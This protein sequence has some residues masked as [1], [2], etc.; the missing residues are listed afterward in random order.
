[1]HRVED[2]A[3]IV[4]E[5]PEHGPGARRGRG[6]RDVP[7][8]EADDR[9]HLA[10]GWDGRWMSASARQPECAEQRRRERER[11]AG[12]ERLAEP[13]DDVR[14]CRVRVWSIV[15]WMGRRDDRRRTVRRSVRIGRRFAANHEVIPRYQQGEGPGWSFDGPNLLRTERTARSL[16]RDCCARHDGIADDPDERHLCVVGHAF[17]ASRGERDPIRS[18][19]AP[20]VAAPRR[21]RPGGRGSPVR[22]QPLRGHDGQAGARPAPASAAA[23]RL[24]GRFAPGDRVGRP[25]HS[26]AGRDSSAGAGTRVRRRSGSRHRGRRLPRLVRRA[27]GRHAGAAGLWNPGVPLRRRC[28]GTPSGPSRR[29]CS[30]T[31]RWSPGRWRGTTG[32]W[33]SVGSEPRHTSRRS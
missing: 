27:P 13:F 19:H 21:S 10:G 17:H 15:G 31:P 14:S 2:S 1:V 25:E 22:G 29:I 4:D 26:R 33:P 18:I 9:E 24:L 32:G 7:P 3:A 6:R 8:T 28:S 5:R 12:A 11:C 23:P 20:S 16:V 30:C